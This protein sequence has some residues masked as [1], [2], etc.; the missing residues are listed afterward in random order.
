MIQEIG[1]K[2]YFPSIALNIPTWVPQ[3]EACIED[4]RVNK[5][6]LRLE[7]FNVPEWDMGLAGAMKIDLLPQLPPS[8]G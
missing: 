2:Y 6:I 5:M 3:S 7:V 4:K 8:G 1:R